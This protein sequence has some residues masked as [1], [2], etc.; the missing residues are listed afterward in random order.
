MLVKEANAN[1]G[2]LSDPSKMPGYAYNLPASKCKMGSKLVNVEGSVCAGCYALKNRYK[3]DNVQNAMHR[4]YDAIER[5]D[6]VE[7]MSLLI[8][9][10]RK[11]Y[12]RWHDSGDIQSVEHLFKIFD[13]CERTAPIQHWLPT[14]E[15]HMV[16]KALDER[17]PPDNLCIRISAHMVDQMPSV[18]IEGCTYSTVHTDEAVF[19]DAWI[20]PAPLQDNNCGGCRR[21]WDKQ[22]PQASYPLH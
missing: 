8:T 7:S 13:V 12:F 9:R 10:A 19:P 1:T 6:W 21:C 3:F 5:D 4:R 20:C 16:R 15:H 11:E 22:T 14:R 2:G 18:E 17:Q